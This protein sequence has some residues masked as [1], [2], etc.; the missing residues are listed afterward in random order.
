MCYKDEVVIGLDLNKGEKQ[1]DV[2]KIFKDGDVLFD[3]YSNQSI[4]VKN[5]I[6]VIDSTYDIVLLEKNK[7]IRT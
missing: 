1:L 3:A 2:S 6:I 4:E 7:K 5:G